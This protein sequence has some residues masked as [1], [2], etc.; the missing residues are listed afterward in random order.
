MLSSGGIKYHSQTEGR[1]KACWNFFTSAEFGRLKSQT[2]HGASVFVSF[3]FRQVKCS[4]NEVF[5]F[6]RQR[7]ALKLLLLSVTFSTCN[8]SLPAAARPHGA[9]SMGCV[10]ISLPPSQDP[11]PASIRGPDTEADRH[12]EH[13]TEL[14]W[15]RALAH[16]VGFHIHKLIEGDTEDQQEG[17]RQMLLNLRIMTHIHRYTQCLSRGGKKEKF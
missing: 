13:D 7:S 1:N 4:K 5:L 17:M 8:S 15:S 14:Q 9:A 6:E 16:Q 10:I 2:L 3:C 12:I 11:L